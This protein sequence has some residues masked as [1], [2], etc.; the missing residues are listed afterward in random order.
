MLK[1]ELVYQAVKSRIISSTY[2]SGYRLV[3]GDLA[4]EF[5]VSALPVRDALSRLEQEG[6][7][8]SRRNVGAQVVGIDHRKVRDE[9]ATV[10]YL[11]GLA[12][13]LAVGEKT[14]SDIARAEAINGEMAK[15]IVGGEVEKLAVLNQAFHETLCLP[16]PNQRL[17]HLLKDEWNWSKV[18][19]EAA[20]PLL[21]DIGSQ[22]VEEHSGLIELLRTGP[23]SVDFERAVREHR[24]GN[25][26]VFNALARR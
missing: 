25:V 12:A 18:L 11:E 19:M 1:W 22:G 20:Y 6:M 15:A 16:C 8:V 3:V 10:A 23:S 21:P 2:T 24:M 13:G 17:E 14:A 5:G 7:I 9:L 4:A 26:D